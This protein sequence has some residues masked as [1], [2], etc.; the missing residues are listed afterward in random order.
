[1]T[2]T[3]LAKLVLDSV[4]RLNPIIQPAKLQAKIGSEAMQEAV[5]RRWVMPDTETGYLHLTRKADVIAEMVKLAAQHTRESKEKLTEVPV[6]SEEFPWQRQGIDWYESMGQHL[7]RP[8]Q[9]ILTPGVGP[10]NEQPMPTASAPAKPNSTAAGAG[11]VAVGSNVTVAEN[12]RVFNGVVQSCESDGTYSL[13]FSGA[14]P[15]QQK[16]YRPEDLNITQSS[17]TSSATR[18]L[19]QIPTTSN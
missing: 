4:N 19:G 15:P 11:K 5:R 2:T 12:G 6:A 13:S 18:P 8:V 14:Q 17:A 1:M 3:E 7:S 16:R 10:S 9:E